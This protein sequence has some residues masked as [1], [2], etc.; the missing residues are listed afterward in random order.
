M[1]EE[2]E[3]KEEEKEIG[4]E[5]TMEQEEMKEEADEGTEAAVE[6]LSQNSLRT[7]VRRLAQTDL[8]EKKL[9]Y[10]FYR[11]VLVPRGQA[12]ART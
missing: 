11:K 3:K 12:Y 6:G 2:K 8:A 4:E 9:F 5:E 10:A 7:R 1:E